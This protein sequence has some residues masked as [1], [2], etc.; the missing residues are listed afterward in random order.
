MDQS[1][2]RIIE[3]FLRGQQPTQ[4]IASL[5]SLDISAERRRRLW[6]LDT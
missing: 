2:M 1:R 5:D 3:T 6:E 4:Q